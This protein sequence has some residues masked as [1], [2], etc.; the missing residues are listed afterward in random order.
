MLRV[1]VSGLRNRQ[2]VEPGPIELVVAGHELTVDGTRVAA[3]AR[4][5][6]PRPH[7][8][9]YR[10]LRAFLV[11]ELRAHLSQAGVGGEAWPE[12][13][14]EAEEAIDDYLADCW[15]TL[16]PQAFLVELLSDPE[17]LQAAAAGLLTDDEVDLLSIPPDVRVGSWQWSAHDVPLLDAADVLLN[18]PPATYEHIVTDEAQ[19]LSPMQLES[20]RRRA[21]TG[22]MTLL[23]DLAQGTSPWPATRGR[24][25][26]CTCGATGCPPRSSSCGPATGCPPRSTRWRCG[27]CRRSPRRSRPRHRSAARASRSSSPARP[28]SRAPR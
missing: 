28:T 1:I 14:A 2:R 20:V 23:G 8:E 16:T 12:A 4:Q 3:R 22:S 13:L 10:E 24:R 7:N 9:A 18:G 15:P 5:L 25:W 26:R 17:E 27:C 19:D 6:S 11:D 21:C